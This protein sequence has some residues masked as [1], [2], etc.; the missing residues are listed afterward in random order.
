MDRQNRL[1]DPYFNLEI[2][3]SSSSGQVSSVSR[4][5]R[6]NLCYACGSCL[7]A[8]P[9]NLATN[10]LQ[11]RKLVMMANFG[12]IEELLQLPEIWYCLSCKRCDHVCPMT[13]KPARLIAHLRI[14]AIRR[15]LVKEKMLTEIQE[16]QRQLQR[17]RAH[18]VAALF[19]G[20]DP[21]LLPDWQK[22]SGLPVGYRDQDFGS[23]E[24]PVDARSV[25]KACSTYLGYPTNLSECFTCSECRNA[26]PVCQEPAVFDPMW[27]LRMMNL[28]FAGDLL[29]SPMMWLCIDCETCTQACMQRVRVHLFIRRIQQIALQEGYVSVAFIRFWKFAQKT[30]YSRFIEE[31]DSLLLFPAVSS[32]NSQPTF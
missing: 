11:P 6:Y 16:L 4:Q 9:V 19:S 32:T 29:S 7:T 3:P 20:R 17:V 8:C 22:L 14:E 5:S 30:I 12:L 15:S 23:K 21:A 13:V 2:I 10:R 18:V 27:M 26:C 31:T 1:P 28:G 24:I 25:R